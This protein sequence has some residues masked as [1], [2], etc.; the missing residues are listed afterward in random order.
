MSC[1]ALEAQESNVRITSRFQASSACA[2]MVRI[3]LPSATTFEISGSVTPKARAAFTV[4]PSSADAS[5]C[6]IA[7]CL[8]SESLRPEGASLARRCASFRRLKNLHSKWAVWRVA[9]FSHSMAIQA[10]LIC[11]L[12]YFHLERS[13]EDTVR[14][15]QAAL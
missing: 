3:W 15:V 14:T 6:F 12:T 9:D 7:N 4:A 2:A 5:Q 8:T 1:V 13:I 11:I 10:S